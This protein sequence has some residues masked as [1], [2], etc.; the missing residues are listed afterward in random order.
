M[1]EFLRFAPNAVEPVDR[2]DDEARIAEKYRRRLVRI[3][4]FMS[5]HDLVGRMHDAH[6]RR[7]ALLDI[8]HGEA[9]EP[10]ILDSY[11]AQRIDAERTNIYNNCF[12]V[13]SEAYAAGT[14]SGVL[15]G[16]DSDPLVGWAN[17]R[18]NYHTLPDG[19]VVAA[20]FTARENMLR[21]N[22]PQFDVLAVRASNMDE[23]IPQVGEL[24]GGTWEEVHP[25]DH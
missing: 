19:T 2:F 8:P 15:H 20:D 18:I 14:A 16:T 5:N 24:Y 10:T 9:I 7:L 23:L 3:T 21:K 12:Q 4:D 17:H 25:K 1:S 13:A 22:D 6:G 11:L